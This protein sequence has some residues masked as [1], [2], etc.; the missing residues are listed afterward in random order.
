MRS[1][2]AGSTMHEH[3]AGGMVYR[4]KEEGRRKK[5]EGKPVE[6]LICKHSG[7]HK[8]V[9]PKGIVEEGEDPKETAVREVE[10]ETGVKAEIVKKI[11]PEVRYKYMKRGI[12]VDKK[13]EFYLMKYVSGNIKDH[14]WEMEDVKWAAGEEA[15][16]LLAFETERKVLRQA[17]RLLGSIS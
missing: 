3:S 4:Q 1:I 7:Y 10:E 6:W 15:L 13:A 5:E 9:L 16:K 17:V 14:S 8:W 2:R 11:M 12:L